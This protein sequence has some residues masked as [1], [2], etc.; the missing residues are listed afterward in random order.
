[1]IS[2]ALTI[3]NKY[4]I[5]TLFASLKHNRYPPGQLIMIL[6]SG[7]LTTGTILFD[8]LLLPYLV[9]YLRRNLFTPFLDFFPFPDFILVYGTLFASELLS[10]TVV[11][12][13]TSLGDRIMRWSNPNLIGALVVVSALFFSMPAILYWLGSGTAGAANSLFGFCLFVLCVT[14]G[15]LKAAH[16][17]L[18]GFLFTK[19]C[20]AV[21]FVPRSV[22]Q[23]GEQLL[24]VVR[25]FFAALFFAIGGAVL[26]HQVVNSTFFNPYS[27]CLTHQSRVHLVLKSYGAL[28]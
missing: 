10:R 6:F 17:L 22:A 25:C 15:L 11:L 12:E 16:A 8:Y 27:L 21:A 9:I 2:Q 7:L 4:I 13:Y 26:Y 23:T 28:E 3:R 20:D 24:G 5:S 19:Y 1:M 14:Q 18:G